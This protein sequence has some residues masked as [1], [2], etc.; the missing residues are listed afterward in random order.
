MKDKGNQFIEGHVDNPFFFFA[1]DESSQ[2]QAIVRF[3]GRYQLKIENKIIIKTRR[4]KLLKPICEG[5]QKAKEHAERA[6]F[7]L[8]EG[9]SGYTSAKNFNSRFITRD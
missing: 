9:G 4:R 1:V 7:L 5:G 2:W 8:R 6:C 3:T